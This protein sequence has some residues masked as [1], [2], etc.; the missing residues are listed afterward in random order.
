[1]GEGSFAGAVGEGSEG[2]AGAGCI[3]GVGSLYP[4]DFPAKHPDSPPITITI[5]I[6]PIMFFVIFVTF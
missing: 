6:T 4:H 1:V 5:S 3:D 2:W